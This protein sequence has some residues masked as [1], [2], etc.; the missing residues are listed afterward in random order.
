[1]FPNPHTRFARRRLRAGI[2]RA[3]LWRVLGLL[4]WL[5]APFAAADPVRVQV[6]LSETGGSYAELVEGLEQ[7]LNARAPGQIRL[8]VQRVPEGTAQLAALLA[9]PPALIVPIGIRATA[10]ALR[11]AGSLPVL[12]LLIPQAS[13]T[14]LLNAAPTTTGQKRSAI[15]LDQPLSRQLDLLQALLP[16]ARRIATLTGPTSQ[17]Q[18]AELQ[19]LSTQ[20]GLRLATQS[21]ADGANPIQALTPLLEQAEV[22]LALPDPAVFNRASLQA[23]LLTTYRSGVPVLGFSQAYVR[24]GALAAVHS[25]AQQ[26]GRQAG[27]WLAELARSGQWQ[28]GAPRYPTY[29]SVSV[30]RQV[31][32]SLGIHVADEATL[33]AQL[34]KRD[35]VQP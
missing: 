33:L 28:L 35:P 19:A 12:S 8:Q 34:R 2:V 23:I 7:Q 31:A 27:D 9:E 24:A 21:V 10:L 14:A 15:Y 11:D 16:G 1:M 5:L 29:Y 22:L 17:A 3:R 30:N 6:L 26:I 25:T 13:Y 20:R 18:T 4:L 32:Q